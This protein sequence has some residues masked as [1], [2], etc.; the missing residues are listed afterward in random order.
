MAGQVENKILADPLNP[1]LINSLRQGGY[2]LYVRH[3]EATIGNDKPQVVFSDCSTQ[4][5][6]SQAGRMQALTYGEVLR[7]L[8]IPVQF[9]ITASPFCRTKESAELAFGEENVQ[10]D[11]Y[12]LNI[13]HLSGDLTTS[14]QE[15]VLTALT[16]VLE[17]KPPTGSNKVI[18]GHSFPRDVGLG[19]IP[20]MG[21]VIVRPRGQ[22]NGYEVIDQIS[23][24]AFMSYLD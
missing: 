11:Y 2:I 8:L 5:N 1:S 23:L 17:I 21:T 12:W 18:I 9:P 13:Y 22:G 6:L 14:E 19:E 15:S 3:G 20:Y 16:S 24:A 10:V 4:R 7:K